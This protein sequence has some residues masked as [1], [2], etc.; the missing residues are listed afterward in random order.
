LSAYSISDWSDFFVAEAGA[1]AA[2]TGL[3]I[4]AISINIPTILKHALLPSRAAESIVPLAGIVI[5]ATVCMVPGQP[6]WVAGVEIVLVGAIMWTVTTTLQARAFLHRVEKHPD[7]WARV[8]LG[9]CTTL[10]IVA[11]GVSLLIGSGGG[12]YW[13]VPGVIVG[14][15]GGIANTWVLLIEILR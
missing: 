5:L 15:I 8:L 14:L 7:Q 11:G 9:Q 10:P 13:L 12:L 4:V 2:L 3:V 6:N 1:A